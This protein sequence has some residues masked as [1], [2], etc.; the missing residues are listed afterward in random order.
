MLLIAY[1][2][3]TA[4]AFSYYLAV[5]LIPPPF[6]LGA[7]SIAKTKTSHCNIELSFRLLDWL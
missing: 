4:S 7:S 2:V 6:R 3:Y 1:S 5:L